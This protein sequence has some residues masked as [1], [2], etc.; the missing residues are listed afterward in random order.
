MA[1]KRYGEQGSKMEYYPTTKFLISH[2]HFIF[3]LHC[4]V[5]HYNAYR[6]PSIIEIPDDT[7]ITEWI[8]DEVDW[9]R[10]NIIQHPMLP[11]VIQTAR[12]ESTGHTFDIHHVLTKPATLY[13]RLFKGGVT[14]SIIRI[15]INSGH[16]C[17]Q[18]RRTNEDYRLS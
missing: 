15:D 9:K 7:P 8:E 5:T 1:E 2:F 12:L 18:H 16:K 11:L 4:M 3:Q 17:F 10:Q 14:C 6:A 13:H